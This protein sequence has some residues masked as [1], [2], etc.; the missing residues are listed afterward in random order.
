LEVNDTD[1]SLVFA[2]PNFLGSLQPLYI[3]PSFSIHS[4][5]GP[6]DIAADLPGSA[7]SAFLDFGWQ[8]DPLRTFGVDLGV[9]V[10]AFT[11]FNTFNS[12]SVRILGKGLGRVRLT[13]NTTLRAGVYYIDRNRYKLVPAGG[14]LWTP[15]PDTRF[16]IFFPEPKLAHYLTTVGTQDVWWYITGY[17][18]GGSWTIT[19]ADD[20]EDSV[21]M[22]EIR[23]MLGAEWGRNEA[24]RQGQ[25]LVF[26]EIGYVFNREL[27]YDA[28]PGDN[29]EIEDS[30]SV[31]VGIGY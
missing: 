13:P 23:L 18:G 9:R 12:D 10:G 29:T 16:D 17:Y 27:L 25:R 8:T 5:A 21:D 19:R 14:I 20:T 4:W 31:R 24:I 6:K 26:A 28:N 7:Y 3:V 11:D 22:N 2:I 30:F 1:T 15:N